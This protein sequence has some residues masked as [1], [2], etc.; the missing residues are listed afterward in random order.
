MDQG[1]RFPK[2]VLVNP[3]TADTLFEGKFLRVKKNGHW[4]YVERC[5]ASGGVAVLAVTENQELVLVEQFRIPLYQRV[6]EIPAG[7]A[8]DMEGGEEE[9]QAEA[10]KRELLE[11]TGFE[12]S[13][14]EF[15]T[16]GPSSA[17][18][19]T[20]VVSF[21][22]ARGLN[23]VA[24]GGGDTSE[25]IQVHLVP[26]QEL[27]SWIA[28]KLAEGCMVDFKVYAALYFHSTPSRGTLQ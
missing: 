10:A 18:L 19:A 22:R 27:H 17:G 12:A 1:L 9:D 3:N 14:M 7:L 4:E 5:K 24:E 8:G 23:R 11:E 28:A 21:F 25:E 13:H 20:E 15:L 16:Q 26:L 6:I 2:I